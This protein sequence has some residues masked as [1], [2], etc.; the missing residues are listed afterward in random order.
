MVY[1]GEAALAFDYLRPPAHV[2]GVG[3]G[4]MQPN[5]DQERPTP[6]V[7]TI[8][9]DGLVERFLSPRRKVRCGGGHGEDCL[10]DVDVSRT[11]G[12]TWDKVPDRL[13]NVETVDDLVRAAAHIWLDKEVGECNSHGLIPFVDR[14]PDR[15]EEVL[16]D[17]RSGMTRPAAEEKYGPI[18]AHNEFYWLRRLVEAPMAYQITPDDLVIELHDSGLNAHQ[19]LRRIQAMGYKVKSHKSITKSL[20]RNGIPPRLVGRGGRR[21]RRKLEPSD[22]AA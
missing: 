16:E 11:A 13:L 6:N 10:C 2:V 1:A 5:R 19:I 18:F 15:I 12:M 22:A 14:V 20:R 3:G 17:V 4:G 9:S 8:T 21:V 7:L